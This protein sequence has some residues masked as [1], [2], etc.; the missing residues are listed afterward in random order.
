MTPLEHSSAEGSIVAAQLGRRVRGS[1]AV[2]R[3]CHLDVPM[4][5]EN[6]PVLDDGSP[7]PTLY[8]LTC[9]MLVKR[10]SALE[11]RGDMMLVNARLTGDAALRTRLSASI[12]RLLERRNQHARITD[13]GAPPGG[14]PD[15]VKCLHAH[16][17]QELAQPGNPIGAGALAETGWPDCRVPCVEVSKD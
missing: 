6:H 7:F 2:V 17:A 13:A 3:R 9:P 8:W 11:A 5:L 1:W 4:V 12:E 10:V 16:V 15:R 14:G